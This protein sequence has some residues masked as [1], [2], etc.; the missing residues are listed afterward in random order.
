[1]IMKKIK[2]P[3]FCLIFSILLSSCASVQTQKIDKRQAVAKDFLFAVK[4]GSMTNEELMKKFVTTRHYFNPDS[5]RWREFADGHID[6][7]RKALKDLDLSSY[8]GYPYIGHEDEF[9]VIASGSL[10][11]KPT[12]KHLVFSLDVARG[13]TVD[14]D[15][16]DLYVFGPQDEKGKG[17]IFLFDDQ[18]R[19][20][21]FASMRFRNYVGYW[22]W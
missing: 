9:A 20:L 4:A 3:K 22:Q 19:I 1:M 8:I 16:K 11:E 13:V 18:N 12:K 5:T 2:A 10:D 7:I 21:S 15:P 14:V 17:M 6:N